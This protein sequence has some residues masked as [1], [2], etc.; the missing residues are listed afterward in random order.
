VSKTTQYLVLKFSSLPD[1]KRFDEELQLR[2]R[3]RDV[4][5]QDQIDFANNIR[6]LDAHPSH[7]KASLAPLQS[8]SLARS[9]I[10]LPPKVDV[11]DSGPTLGDSISELKVVELSGSQRSAPLEPDPIE[12]CGDQTLFELLATPKEGS[13]DTIRDYKPLGDSF[14][15]L[16]AAIPWFPA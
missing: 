6:R 2:F 1:K 3:L 4:Q 9:V 12:V 11:P 14:S 16:P 10:S 8:P 15:E 5:I 13:I 7:R